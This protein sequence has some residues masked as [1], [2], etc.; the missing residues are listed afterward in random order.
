MRATGDRLH[1]PLPRG[2]GVSGN[3]FLAV[4]RIAGAGGEQDVRNEILGFLI[5]CELDVVVQ[6]SSTTSDFPKWARRSFP[7]ASAASVA[8]A[9]SSSI[10]SA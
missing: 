5:E 9:R 3:A 2:I 1:D 4:K 7:A 8:R 6:P 10:S